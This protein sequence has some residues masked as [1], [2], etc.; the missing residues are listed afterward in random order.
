[1]T[2]VIVICRTYSMGTSHENCMQLGGKFLIRIGLLW[3]QQGNFPDNSP[4]EKQNIIVLSLLFCLLYVGCTP[5][6]LIK[7]A[8][9]TKHIL[10]SQRKDDREMI[11]TVLMDALPNPVWYTGFQ[12]Q[13]LNSCCVLGY[14]GSLRYKTLWFIIYIFRIR[15]FIQ[16]SLS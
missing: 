1:M 7:T 10:C 11:D 6:L 2:D 8:D 15:I 5:W 14:Q 12:Q 4:E 3:Q 9:M 16:M 13:Y